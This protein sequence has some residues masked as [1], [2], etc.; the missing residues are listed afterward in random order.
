MTA[1]AL[2]L[3]LQRPL[4]DDAVVVVACGQTGR[5]ACTFLRH[6]SW[7]WRLDAEGLSQPGVKGIRDERPITPPRIPVSTDCGRGRLM[8]SDTAGAVVGQGAEF[9]KALA[10]ADR[11]KTEAA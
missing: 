1:P 7:V 10:M 9:R 6:A 2:E 5:Q 8:F 11:P 3:K 4:A